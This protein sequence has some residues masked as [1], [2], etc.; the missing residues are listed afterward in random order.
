M[1][2]TGIYQFGTIT[3]NN[4]QT[5]DFDNIKTDSDGKISQ[6]AYNFIQKELGLDTVEFSDEPQKTE[7][8]VTDFEFVLWNQEKQMQ[9]C[10]DGLCAQ[11][12]TE[13]IGENSKYAQQVLSELRQFMKNFKAENS[14]EPEKVVD[15]AARFAEEL[16]K[17]Y[18]EIKNE[19]L[20][21]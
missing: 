18:A 3:T 2:F 12:A 11:I 4:G 7:K 15:M 20:G 8:E 14:S 21:Q 9:E 10:F 5:I 16:P 13:L 1:S 17:L 6:R 19:I